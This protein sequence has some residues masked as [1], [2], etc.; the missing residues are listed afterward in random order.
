MHTCMYICAYISVICVMR[1]GFMVC[2]LGMFV[3]LCGLIYVDI[4]VCIY[5][6]TMCVMRSDFIVCFLHMCRIVWVDICGY[7]RMYICVYNVCYA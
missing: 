2:F 4:H 5:V 6:Y 3:E 7:T 1:S